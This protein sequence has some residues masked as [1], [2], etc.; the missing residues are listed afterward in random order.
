MALNLF[1]KNATA[2]LNN[3][4]GMGL[5]SAARPESSRNV[6]SVTHPEHQPR[7]AYAVSTMT[8]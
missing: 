1:A 2:V 7:P 6:S 4:A 3:E 8:D 5:C